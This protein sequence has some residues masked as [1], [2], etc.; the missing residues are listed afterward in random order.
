[1]P[2]GKKDGEMWTRSKSSPLPRGSRGEVGHVCV[3]S[4]LMPLVLSEGIKRLIK[5]L[6]VHFV[7][8]LRRGQRA[9]SHTRAEPPSALW[10]EGKLL[11]SARPYVSQRAAD[12]FRSQLQ[13]GQTFWSNYCEHVFKQLGYAPSDVNGFLKGCFHV[14]THRRWHVFMGNQCVLQLSTSR[15]DELKSEPGRALKKQV[16]AR[17]RVT[18]GSQWH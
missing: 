1:M 18:S 10:A 8:Y 7:V 3:C 2:R 9:H 17:D 5:C 6:R 11:A 12:T 14:P 13:S 4:F 16:A 15:S